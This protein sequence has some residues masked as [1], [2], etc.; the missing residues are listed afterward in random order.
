MPL[1]YSAPFFSGARRRRL[2][3]AIKI[4]LAKGPLLVYY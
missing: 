4:L 2:G 3:S 1:F